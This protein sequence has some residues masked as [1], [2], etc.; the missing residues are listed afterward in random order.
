MGTLMERDGH[1]QRQQLERKLFPRLV[2]RAAER[3]EEEGGNRHEDD[4]VARCVTF[5][6]SADSSTGRAALVSIRPKT[7]GVLD[8]GLVKSRLAALARRPIRMLT[9][10]S[11]E[12][13]FSGLIE[14]SRAP[15]LARGIFR[16][17]GQIQP[18]RCG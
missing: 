14:K 12:P 10:V 8:E 16:S 18:I 5:H 13:H 1:H 11:A 6:T 3:P 7:G 15:A 2:A 4:D 17:S 9:K